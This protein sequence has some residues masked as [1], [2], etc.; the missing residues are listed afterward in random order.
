MKKIY[1]DMDGT[2]YN[3]YGIKNWLQMLR[4]EERGAFTVG[5][6]LVD[7]TRLEDVCVN[8]I[9]KGYQIGIITWLPIGASVEYMEI[10]TEEKR[11]WVER[12]MP[13][14]SEFYAQ[15]Y[16]TPKQYAPM[17][18]AA[19]MWLVDDN[20]EVREMWVTEKQRKAIDA[21]NDILEALEELE[22][23]LK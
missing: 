9:K 1:F 5:K 22:R 8:L 17:K 15:E 6:P 4:N 20:K 13:Y 12:Y 19:E 3:L 10:C 7:M 16:G 18:R 23:G 11:N 14:V 21:N 2:V